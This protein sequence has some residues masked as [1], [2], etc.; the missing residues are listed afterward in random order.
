MK[1]NLFKEIWYYLR[2]KLRQFK[3]WFVTKSKIVFGN[4][5]K[6]LKS[7]KVWI[8][9]NSIP[10]QRF[11]KWSRLKFRQLKEWFVPKAKLAINKIHQSLKPIWLWIHKKSLPLQRKLK[12]ISRKVWQKISSWFAKLSVF[13]QK[14]FPKLTKKF[15]QLK[16]NLQR[17]FSKKQPQ[18]KENAYFEHSPTLTQIVLLVSAVISLIILVLLLISVLIIDDR[19]FYFGGNPITYVL[20]SLVL[21]LLIDFIR[22][23]FVH[24]LSWSGMPSYDEY[25]KSIDKYAFLQRKSRF[26]TLLEYD[27]DHKDFS[28]V[29]STDKLTLSNICYSFRDFNAK[30][31]KLFYSIDDIRKFI[32]G[33]AVSKTMI[34]Q[35]MSGTGKTSIAVAFGRFIN[36]PSTIVPIQPMWKERSDLLGYYN[37][38][39]G[40]FTETIILQKLYEASFSDKMFLIVL[41]EMNIA[42]VEYYFSEFL[43]LLELPPSANRQLTIASSG[44]IGDPRKMKRG[45]MVLP[46]NVWFLGTANNDDSTFAI[47]DKVYDRAMIINLENRSESFKVTQDVH[48]IQ[49]STTAF[50]Q[51]IDQAK[52]QQISQETRKKI[53]EFDQFLIRNANITFGN[54]VYHQFELY[55]PIFMACGGKE[56]EALDDLISKKILRKLESKNPVFVKSIKNKLILKL[57]EVFGNGLMIQ[58]IHYLQKLVDNL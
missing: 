20:I 38:F 55:I 49:L 31:L 4:I 47:S 3:Q 15:S 58:S 41:D 43:S 22:I 17:I 11:F 10:L 33:F 37:E 57:D 6:R 40:K 7:M 18:E 50:Y 35:G 29:H 8:H 21:I 30:E 5:Q 32:A 39:T 9:K 51:L 1:K 24:I 44:A 46:D 13:F 14:R 45:R 27:K 48:P 54:R 28:P 23:A 2:I 34:L 25:K 12:S 42:R 16:I 53:R 26:S 19:S 36:V 52:K 56:I